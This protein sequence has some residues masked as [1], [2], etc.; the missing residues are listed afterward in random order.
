LAEAEPAQIFKVLIL[1]E[2]DGSLCEAD[3]IRHQGSLWLVPK[4]IDSPSEKTTRPERIIR[5][6]N[7]PMQPGGSMGNPSAPFVLNIAIPKSVLEGPIQSQ[8][9]GNFVV[10]GLPNIVFPMKS[11]LH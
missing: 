10:I 1:I 3:A 11:R 5:L 6:D 4:W 7:L 2:D 8:T 9:T